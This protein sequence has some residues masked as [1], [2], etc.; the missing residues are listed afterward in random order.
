MT[1]ANRRP[2]QWLGVMAGCEVD[3]LRHITVCN[4]EC[5]VGADEHCTTESASLDIL[6]CA[7]RESLCLREREDGVGACVK[8]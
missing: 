2:H 8:K 3:V 6:Q 7:D 1:L 4:G 5:L